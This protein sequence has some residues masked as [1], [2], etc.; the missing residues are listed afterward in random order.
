MEVCCIARKIIPSQVKLLHSL[1]WTLVTIVRGPHTTYRDVTRAGDE[2]SRSWKFLNHG[3]S[4]IK[5]DGHSGAIYAM[6]GSSP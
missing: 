2:P 4:K 6:V 3:E 5:K 1:D